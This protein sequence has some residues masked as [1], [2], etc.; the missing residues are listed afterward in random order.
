MSDQL[1]YSG[2]AKD[3]FATDNESELLMVYKDQATAFN[4]ERKEQIP[5]KGKLNC[6]ISSYIFDY[7]IKNG[8]TTHLVKNVS[9]HEQLVL[10]TELIPVEVVLRNKIAGSFARKFGLDEGK[11]LQKPIIEFYYK[12]DELDD[13]FINDNQIESLNIA[14]E[15]ELTYIKEQ[16]LKINQLLIKLFSQ[17]DLDLVDFKLEFGRVDGKII[18]IDEFSPDNC[19]LWDSQSHQS[20]DKD[21]FRKNQADLVETYTKVLNRLEGAK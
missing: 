13:P 20:L 1:I 5:G 10:K 8:I 12:S 11:D 15:A 19:R 4:G 2:K 18:L 16:T 14:T 7:L 6:Q 3:V 17:D 21:V 9:D